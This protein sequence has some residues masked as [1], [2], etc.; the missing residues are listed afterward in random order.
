MTPSGGLRA[1][2]LA[3][4]LVFWLGV[5]VLTFRACQ[6][7]SRGAAQPA[8]VTGALTDGSERDL[9]RCRT[10]PDGDQA[11]RA[12]WAAARQRFFGGPAS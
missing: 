11:C 7:P 2:V 12:A 10:A 8:V 1:L 5:A 6:A 4:T 3:A 9:A